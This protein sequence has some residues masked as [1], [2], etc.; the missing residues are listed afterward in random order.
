MMIFSF[1]SAFKAGCDLRRSEIRYLHSFFQKKLKKP[2]KF[3][4]GDAIVYTDTE[5]YRISTSAI[6]I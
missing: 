5:K 1:L 3:L 2:V 4:P 6:H